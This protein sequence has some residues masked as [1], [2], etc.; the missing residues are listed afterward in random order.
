MRRRP[1][2]GRKST[3][4][5]AHNSLKINPTTKTKKPTTTRMKKLLLSL[6][7][8]GLAASAFAQGATIALDNNANNNTSPTATSGGLFFLNTGG[9]PQLISQDFSA[10][11]YGGT[12]SANLVLIQ[13]FF[14]PA[15]LGDNTAGGG[16]FTDLSGTAYPVSG[17]TT[18]STSAFFRIEAWL[19]SFTT[20]AAATAAGTFTG[21][22][23]PFSNPVAAP[24]NATPDFTSMPAI[25]LSSV[26]EPGTFALAGLGAAAL[27][28]F[29]RRK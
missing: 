3:P 17:T 19:G 21:A 14:G 9:G 10:A 7:L 6:A 27:L 23:L 5:H 18:A 2:I 16:T 26:P 11:F 25:I 15:T 24:P 4:F 22:S 8:T 1:T 12:D 29:R 28:I 20:Y 13:S